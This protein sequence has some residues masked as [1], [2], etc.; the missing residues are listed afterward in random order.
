MPVNGVHY[1]ESD[2]RDYPDEAYTCDKLF[3]QP[4]TIWKYD[5]TK[6]GFLGESLFTTGH[7]PSFYAGVQGESAFLGRSESA[8]GESLWVKMASEGYRW[9]GLGAVHFWMADTHGRDLQFLAA[10]GRLVP[11][12]ELDLRLRQQSGADAQ[13]LQRHALCR[14]HRRGLATEDRP[15][16]RRARRQDVQR[17]PGHGRAIRDRAGHAPA[18]PGADHGPTGAHRQ[19]RRQGGLSRC[20]TAGGDRSG[21]RGPPRAWRRTTCWSSIRRAASRRGWRPGASTSPKSPA[22]RPCRPRPAWCSSAPMPS[23]PSSRPR[24]SG[25]SWPPTGRASS[26]WSRPIRCTTRRLPA[27]LEPT[28]Y[29]GRVAFSENLEHPVFAGLGQEDFFTWSKRPR[30]LSQRLQEGGQGLPLAGAMRAGIGLLGDG[31]VPGERRPDDPLPI[32]GWRE[33]RL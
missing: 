26:S 9:A 32:G 8:K 7:A 33:A 2:L 22:S 27:D 18:W 25:W 23:R 28:N 24:P 5:T 16:D 13:G 6:P 4:Q 19:P 3:H 31:R 20:Q 21:R 14:P 1:G 17:G 30:R 12:V 29:V 10:G 15:G 11:A